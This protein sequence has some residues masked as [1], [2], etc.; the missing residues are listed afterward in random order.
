MAY[1]VESLRNIILE[2][3]ELIGKRSYYPRM[4]KVERISGKA[5]IVTGIRRCGKTVYENLYAGKLIENGV[6]RRNICIIDFSDDR[7]TE[8]RTTEPDSIIEAYYGLFP[9]KSSEK[10]YYFF[11]E[12]QYLNNWEL[13]INRLQNTRNCEINIT[14][15]SAKL[16]VREI[17][18]EFGGRGLSWEL[19]PFSFREFLETKEDKD[20]FNDVRTMT[21]DTGRLCYKYFKE[22]EHKGGFPESLAIIED[23]TRIRYL[24]NLAETVIF[25][26]VI[27]RYNIT[28]PDGG[29][30][31]MQLLL[32]EMSG[33]MTFTK[34]K[35][36]L[37]GEQ[38]R[39]SVEMIKD[40]TGYLEEA[41]LIFTVE[42]F[43][44]NVAARKT[45]P[46]KVYCVDHS[47]ALVMSGSLTLDKG[48]ILENIVFMHL[49]RSTD[50]I[51]Y[52]KTSGGYEI[53][54]AVLSRG[55]RLS[56]N[57][58][59]ELIQVSADID[60]ADTLNREVRALSEGMAE[61]GTKKS[62]LITENTEDRIE[63][64]AGVINVLPAWKYLLIEDNLL[65]DSTDAPW[66]TLKA[67][68]GTIPDDFMKD[69]EQ[70]GWDEVNER[71]DM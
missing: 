3:Q 32:G 29:Y 43:S 39:L 26:D 42:I 55:Q 19:F 30:R 66:A 40:I 4:M 6:D 65:F 33:L 62:I 11:D 41:Y 21:A 67:S 59:P 1:L 34:Q 15:S 44:L 47:V 17:A 10:V 20:T 14:G 49:R 12:I 13:F 2:N 58:V 31:L 64:E 37:D 35:K 60:N 5:T 71:E 46:K 22:Y 27:R 70:P 69:R 50:R 52:A 48:K 68:I 16:L 28:N 25:R 45:N 18:T 57:S 23:D 61:Y 63:T 36:R 8:M 54:F 38:Y 51:F 7:L 56:E 53:D 24:Q 9:E